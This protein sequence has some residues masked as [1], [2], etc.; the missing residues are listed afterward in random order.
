M[1]GYF[2]LS[3]TG[4]SKGVLFFN[5][6]M[7]SHVATICTVGPILVD[8]LE[9]FFGSS[10][11]CHELCIL[12]D[13]SFRAEIYTYFKTCYRDSNFNAS[14]FGLYVIK[15]GNFW[16]PK[17]CAD[18]TDAVHSPCSWHLVNHSHLRICGDALAIKIQFETAA[19]HCSVCLGGA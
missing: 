6:F 16:L 5:F 8:L 18:I 14:T 11:H 19:A 3:T 4:P 7:V 15:G 9:L 2:S 1:A 10:S 12:Q 17:K 13:I